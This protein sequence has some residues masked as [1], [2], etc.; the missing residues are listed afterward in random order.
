MYK[1]N[2]FTKDTFT[3]GTYLEYLLLIPEGPLSTGASLKAR[4]VHFHLYYLFSLKF[5]C[6][7]HVQT[8]DNVLAFGTSY[9]YKWKV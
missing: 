6:Y 2:T 4:L 1:T 8:E 5:W 7:Y 3:R 9:R